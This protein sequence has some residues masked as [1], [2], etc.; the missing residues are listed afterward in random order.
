M[1]KYT[2]CEMKAIMEVKGYS[3]NTIKHYI[4]HISNLAAYFNQ[5]PHTLSP[6]HIH[7]YQVFLVQEKQISWSFFNQA[8]CSIRF[9]FNHVVGNDWSV[10]HIPFQKKHKKLPV[11]LSR[12]EINSS[13]KIMSLWF[14]IFL[15]GVFLLKTESYTSIKV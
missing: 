12:A 4:D 9:F 3:P 14:Y 10:K 1:K 2:R 5:P 15:K 7:K 8:V 11:V 6:E 13:Y